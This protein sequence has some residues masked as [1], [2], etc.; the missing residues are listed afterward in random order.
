MRVDT[1]VCVGTK[2]NTRDNSSGDRDP[3]SSYGIAN[4][5]DLAF[6]RRDVSKFQILETFKGRL[7]LNLQ[8]GK[9]TVMGDVDDTGRVLLG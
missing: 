3:V 2:V 7:I 5:P 6:Q 1:G 4:C 8:Q 9:I